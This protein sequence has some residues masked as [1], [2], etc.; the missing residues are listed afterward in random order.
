MILSI[1]LKSVRDF[2]HYGDSGAAAT[3]DT[4]LQQNS[5]QTLD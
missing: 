2:Q 3:V 5:Q 4:M 1:S